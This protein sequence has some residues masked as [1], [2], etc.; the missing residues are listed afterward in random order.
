MTATLISFTTKSS[1]GTDLVISRP[2]GVE[3]GDLLVLILTIGSIAA[4]PPTL[5]YPSVAWREHAAASPITGS[6]IRTL[7]AFKYV[8]AVETPSYT[9]TY[10]IS[11]PM[12]GT[13][14]AIRGAARDFNYNPVLYPYGYFAPG[15][16]V[17]ASSTL[18]NS[19]IAPAAIITTTTAYTLGLYL[20]T[21]FDAAA[22]AP[23]LDDPSPLVGIIHRTQT[24]NFGVL[25]MSKRYDTTGVAATISV[26]SSLS[27]P[28]LAVSLGVESAELLSPED[29]YKSKLL[30][31]TL[32]PPYDTRV[33]STIGKLLTVIGTSDNE[34]GGLF[35]DDDFLPFD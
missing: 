28:W 6:G 33:S 20:F 35:G 12:V 24:A 30:R 22:G 25:A 4:E 32:P 21:Q 15:A 16:P 27:K 23:I 31:R 11:R 14:L 2:D 34:I 10:T 1:T 19:I 7:Q 5:I 29:N 8:E 3:E 26:R 9:F 13:L 18:T 17:L